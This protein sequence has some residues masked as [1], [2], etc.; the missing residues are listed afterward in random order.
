MLLLGTW[1]LHITVI[2]TA[3]TS[4]AID[5]DKSTVQVRVRVEPAATTPEGEAVTVTLVGAGTKLRK[6]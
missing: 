5:G 6:R 1:S 3:V 2:F 4:S